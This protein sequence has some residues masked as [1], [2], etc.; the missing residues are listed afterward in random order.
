MKGNIRI[1]GALLFSI[2]LVALGLY[3]RSENNTTEDGALSVINAPVKQYIE[4]VDA[5]KN[6]IPD[7]QEELTKNVIVS[8]TATGTPIDGNAEYTPPTTY[9]GQFAESFFKEYLG[10]KAGGQDFSDPTGLVNDAVQ[11]I[12]ESTASKVYSRAEIM[13]VPTADARAY[14]NR[15]AEIIL[16]NP[17]GKES[18]IVILERALR[19]NDASVL[20]ELKPIREAYESMIRDTLLVPVPEEFVSEHL[21]LLN[22]YEAILTDIKAAEVIFQDPLY[23]LAR[24]KRYSDDVQGMLNAFVSISQ[25]L[26]NQN[27]SYTKEELGAFF[28]VFQ[29]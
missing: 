22:A 4:S 15:I 26:K 13:V 25:A 9:T 2:A 16:K 29:Q 28:L 10:G 14:G 17:G 7:W 20:D 6:G 23:G 21:L 11:S 24:M 12:E 8:I 27:I 19:E 3:S 5:D 18:E 1:L